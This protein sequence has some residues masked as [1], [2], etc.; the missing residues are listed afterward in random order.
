MFVRRCVAGLSVLLIVGIAT[1][2]A[3]GTFTTQPERVAFFRVPAGET[4]TELFTIKLDG[5]GA[6]RL[7][8]NDIPEYDPRISPDGSRIV[9]WSVPAGGTDSEL[10]TIWSDGSHRRRLT[11]DEFFDGS[12]T[13]S[14]TGGRI[15]WVSGRRSDQEDIFTMHPDGTHIQRV[16][17]SEGPEWL[18][19]WS[20]DGDVIVFSWFDVD[21]DWEVSQVRLSPTG[22]GFSGLTNND[23]VADFAGDWSPDGSRIVFWSNRDGDYEVFQ[24][25]PDGSHV[26]RVTDND[27]N[28]LYPFYEPNGS[29]IYLNRFLGADME[30]VSI[31]SDGTQARKVTDND[32]N[33]YLV[34][35]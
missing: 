24:M 16:T 29:R 32:L 26:R 17:Y 34:N 22:N 5:T 7:T 31:R 27:F 9:F 11:D 10:Y 3:F 28:D 13:W 1:P 14:P 21:G 33:D 19:T 20:P 23:G 18:P 15:A 6:K 4:D 2:P 8:H 30:I 25:W 12:A 35:D